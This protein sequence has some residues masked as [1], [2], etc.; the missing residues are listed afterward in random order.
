[1]EEDNFT[2]ANYSWFPALQETLASFTLLGSAELALR[3]GSWFVLLSEERSTYLCTF[4]GDATPD[5]AGTH[6]YHIWVSPAN[7]VNFPKNILEI[8]SYAV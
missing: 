5:C 6:P 8:G 7:R 1:V 4:L 3:T 2:G